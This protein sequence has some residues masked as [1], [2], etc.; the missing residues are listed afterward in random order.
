MQVTP[1]PCLKDNYAYLVVCEDTSQ[2]GIVDPSEAA[3]VLSAV[4]RAG[5]ELVAIL[6]THHHWDH[7]GGNKELLQRFPGLTVYGHASDKGRIEGQ[8]R[9]LNS[10]DTF[11]LG[12]LEVRALHNPGHTSGAVSYVIDEHAF[13]GDTM[14]AAGCGRLFEGTPQMM[15]ESLCKVIGSLS[16]RTQVHFGH[17]YTETNLRFAAT[18]E[19]D[20]QAVKSKLEAVR[21]LRAQGRFSTPSTLEEEW[22]TNPFMRVDSPT[23]LAT[24]RKTDPTNDGSPVAV[25]ATLRAMKDRF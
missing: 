11:R 23:I 5:V 25:L 2:A 10:G 1:I 14:F 22:Q 4:Q 9:F 18:V 24:V 15:Y 13:T 21:K 17:E 3:P 12:K 19:P 8:T 16:R 7:V 20:N 6:N